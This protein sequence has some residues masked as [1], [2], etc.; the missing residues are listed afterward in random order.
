MANELT[1]LPTI[2]Y[3]GLT[4][5]SVVQEIKNIIENNPNWKENWTQ[6]YSSE[7]GTMLVQLMA[8]ITENLAVRQDLLYNELFMT[9]STYDGDKTRLIKQIGYIREGSNGA[10]VPI[11]VSLEQPAFKTIN[12]S[13]NRKDQS[14]SSVKNAI[15]KFTAKDIN[16]K[17]VAWEILHVDSDGK[18][19]YTTPIQLTGNKA[20]F[21]AYYFSDEQFTLKAIQ[22]E[23][24]Y[25]EF[26]S[27]TDDG[28][29]FSTGLKN[30]DFDS[31]EVFDLTEG[32]NIKVNT[33]HV[34]VKS[35]QDVV[36][37]ADDNYQ[38]CYIL[39]RDKNDIITFRYPSKTLMDNNSIIAKHGFKAGHKIAI[40]YRVS[41]G[42]DGN[43]QA[44][45]FGKV[46]KT[47]KTID[48][49]SVDIVINNTLAGYG[50]RDAETTEEASNNAPLSLRHNERSVNVEDFDVFMLKNSLVTSSK[51]YM[52]YNEPEEFK[53]AFGRRIHPHESYSLV[54]LNKGSQNIPSKKLNDYPWI[55]LVKE[56]VL[57]EYYNFFNVNINREID[58]ISQGNSYYLNVKK[59]DNKEMNDYSVSNSVS[60]LYRNST[61]FSTSGAL[62]STIQEEQELAG[63]PK[64]N[65]YMQVKVHLTKFD[66]KYIKDITNDL[67]SNDGYNFT[68]KTND[69]VVVDEGKHAT[70]T[71]LTSVSSSSDYVDVLSYDTMTVVL[72]D[73]IKFDVSLRGEN[74]FTDF[75][76]LYDIDTEETEP[77]TYYLKWDNDTNFE[78]NFNQEQKIIDSFESL[79]KAKSY[80]E[81]EEI[82]SY[83][84]GILQIF[85]DAYNKVILNDDEVK[86]KINGNVKYVD[87][88]LQFPAKTLSKYNNFGEDDFEDN[89]SK[90]LFYQKYENDGKE[91][92]LSDLKKFYRIK[93]N[94]TIYAVRIDGYSIN[95][96]SKYLRNAFKD[97]DNNSLRVSEGK[98]YDLFNYIGYGDT[99][100]PIE[101]LQ[102]AKKVA[103][104]IFEN[105]SYDE[106]YQEIYDRLYGEKYQTL[107]N[108][109]IQS[110][111]EEKWEQILKDQDYL[112]AIEAIQS[113]ENR[114]KIKEELIEELT[115]KIYEE[116]YS[117]LYNSIYNELYE[118]AKSELDTKKEE[119]YDIKF[120]EFKA[121]FI[122]ELTETYW[123]S[124]KEKY[125]QS[126]IDEY[127]AL[128][129][130]EKLETEWT[131]YQKTSAYK[132]IYNSKY[133]EAYDKIKSDI[134]AADN[135]GE[136]FK[137]T[138]F[139]RSSDGKLYP[140]EFAAKYRIDTKS[141][142]ILFDGETV[143]HSTGEV[144]S[145]TE[146]TELG[147]G[148]SI[149]SSD[150]EG[151]YN[152]EEQN[153]VSDSTAP[154]LACR[155]TISS[156]TNEIN[157]SEEDSIHIPSR[158][159]YETDSIHTSES[160]YYVYNKK[161]DYANYGTV[162]YSY[163]SD[164]KTLE[165]YEYY[166]YI[167]FTSRTLEDLMTEVETE[168]AAIEESI[169]EEI[170]AEWEKTAGTLTDDEIADQKTK[171]ETDLRSEF[172]NDDVEKAEI[173]EQ[174]TLKAQAEA[175]TY[176]ANNLLEYSSV[177]TTEIA[178]AA[179]EQA[180]GQ[181]EAFVNAELKSID[182]KTE[183][184][185]SELVEE[186]KTSYLSSDVN[187]MLVSEY[188][189]GILASN[190]GKTKLEELANITLAS[191]EATIEE[192]A[193]AAFNSQ[194]QTEVTINEE[195]YS[196]Q[197]TARQ[198]D[199]TSLL[200]VDD[201]S[202]FTY[203]NSV[204]ETDDMKYCWLNID[205]LAVLLNFIFSK[206]NIFSNI[207]YYY[208]ADNKQWRDAISNGY[209]NLNINIGV[210]LVNRKHYNYQYIN[211]V[212]KFEESEYISSHSDEEDED[213]SETV[214]FDNDEYDLRFENISSEENV[215]ADDIE[216]S[217]VGINELEFES[218]EDKLKTE[219]MITY[220]F[221]A[222]RKYSSVS[223][224][225]P[226]Y[227]DYEV[228]KI[229]ISN[230][231]YR[232]ILS[233]PSYGKNASVY[234]YG[235]GYG[236]GSFV[237]YLKFI[238]NDFTNDSNWWQSNKAFGF[239][240]LEMV[241]DSE[242]TNNGN[243][244]FTDND[245]NFVNSPSSIY[246]SYKLSEV[247]R[248]S[249]GK[250]ENFYY[251]DSEGN[252]MD[253]ETYCE[254]K[255]INPFV[256]IEGQ[257]VY[258][259]SNKLTKKIDKNFSEYC[260][261]LTDDTVDDTSF[262]TIEENTLE[263]LNSI[264]S[265]IITFE[266]NSIEKL[267]DLSGVVF[268]LKI[269]YDIDTTNKVVLNNQEYENASRVFTA[270][271]RNLDK[272]SAQA[273]LDEIYLAIE[274]NKESA[275]NEYNS[276][277]Y[278]K[279]LC[280]LKRND[281]NKLIFRNL[282]RNGGNIVFYYPSDE[283]L[284]LNYVDTETVHKFYKN[285][286]GTNITNKT[287]Y[288]L[289]PKE[290]F[291]NN[292][293]V[294]ITEGCDEG[295]YFYSPTIVGDTKK[296]LVFE[297]RYAVYDENGIKTT[298]TFDYYFDVDDNDIS[299]V[300]FD[301]VKTKTSEFPDTGFYLHYIHDRTYEERSVK[302]EEETLEEY[303]ND[304]AIGG[305]TMHCM[306]PAFRTFDISLQIGY[307]ANFSE[308]AVAENVRNVISEEYSFDITKKITVGN[309]IYLSDIIKLVLSVD[310]V[311]NVY[312]N[313][314]G[315]DISD[316]T[317]YPTQTKYL[318]DDNS[319]YTMLVLADSDK[320]HGLQLTFEA[321]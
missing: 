2:Q 265:D 303:M 280:N 27:T 272:L 126:L 93:I 64:E 192:E 168:V 72:D 18:I 29:I 12:L 145:P 155:L 235:D 286:F 197:Y 229:D 170:R 118:K 39:E 3:T 264:K 149:Y 243:F 67:F 215:E 17:N 201:T 211:D 151:I 175:K 56:H 46:S 279:V 59:Y 70:L 210:E 283:S 249:I 130:K 224:T 14:L 314:F 61:V 163:N 230:E 238:T 172:D 94:G 182:V 202:D 120:A 276:Y 1:K 41:N 234:V 271:V 89:I 207:L 30:F 49:D 193:Q 274:K 293:D 106:I 308:N 79:S 209:N 109:Y 262:Y 57:N 321:V 20:V 189:K 44:N 204:V 196:S 191:V 114:Q 206:F 96:I 105:S 285:L 261:K 250:R 251:I 180:D 60:K 99:Y 4:Y 38:P 113:D 111:T 33:K 87:L 121:A 37:L 36:A 32:S 223:E 309:R 76:A 166:D 69:N 177:N 144:A 104:E 42:T 316:Q 221:G 305:T 147:N 138:Y 159:E 288:E 128:K 123:A 148:F 278:K 171:A 237:N 277:L 299:N 139:Y 156:D 267:E 275:T 220:L 174:A 246:V 311:E 257:I 92:G 58:V 6:F 13:N 142:D 84:R 167:K 102:H 227:E 103:T 135:G 217:S 198:V 110:L 62:S 162:D 247:D 50:G 10:T 203:N 66:G 241:V 101:E 245:G 214:Y 11:E 65:F 304:Y 281:A 195:N 124:Y 108:E 75:C 47:V 140:M 133:E 26:S 310:G 317:T 134:I 48:G 307:N 115:K 77:E 78:D 216:V 178:A 256:S 146:E 164:V 313:Y 188:I 319:F 71:S 107:K 294:I 90:G 160:G 141:Y 222:M 194:V 176:I 125:L 7:A 219:D 306:K 320:Y 292:P 213:L 112:D 297:Y 117:E 28:V 88:G 187:E 85:R 298:K 290:Y 253:Y 91:L 268:P 300:K 119:I 302:I 24:R 244:I 179:K 25:D 185:I 270:N 23:T 260:I 284:E 301:I 95:L 137:N 315:Y 184:K 255:M 157:I 136:E 218:A 200:F 242:T 239:E 183:Q 282:N 22:G 150:D 73:S 291:E 181:I 240:S 19:S 295:E 116:K 289:Y 127:L 131:A 83:R 236:Q 161:V 287:F 165:G 43:V 63:T 186:Y 122:K 231:A 190:V 8:W 51:T 31:F 153:H 226:N 259:D 263:T 212:F 269:G 233:S 273:V 81:G 100:S 98:Y 228:I 199:K 53:T 15:L 16:G 232:F 208:D 86:A 97:G 312:A 35:F 68:F 82:A 143:H 266:T 248:L 45:Y 252:E 225:S 34:R 154:D 132:K 52:P 318:E 158:D 40:L 173:L 9:T 21:T 5:D 205:R 296:N 129:K 152:V 80:Y 254:N 169:V 54:T 74:N 55:D 258:Y